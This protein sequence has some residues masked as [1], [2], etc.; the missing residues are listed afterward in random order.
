M[1]ITAL[2]VKKA[3]LLAQSGI[4]TNLPISEEVGMNNNSF[5]HFR[6]DI[7][8]TDVTVVGSI[9]AKL[10]MKSP[11]GTFVDLSGT[12]ATVSITAAGDF[13]LTQLVERTA[14]QVNMPLKETVR[15]VLATTNAGDAVTIAAIYLYK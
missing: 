1:K 12:N 6:A 5:L 15:V 14:D 4:V 8:A 13:S 9:T 10:Q 3:G 11:G 7:R 2:N